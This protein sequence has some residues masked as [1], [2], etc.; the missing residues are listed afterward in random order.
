MIKCFFV[1]IIFEKI[2]DGVLFSDT[3]RILRRIK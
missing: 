3:M 2:K 1:E